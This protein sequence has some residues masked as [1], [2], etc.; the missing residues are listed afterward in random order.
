VN[1]RLTEAQI[2]WIRA[3]T[4]SDSQLAR[5]FSVNRRTVERARR[6]ITHGLLPGAHATGDKKSLFEA[7]L[8]GEGHMTQVMFT[9]R[10]RRDPREPKWRPPAK[11]L[12]VA[13]I[14]SRGY[15][16][17]AQVR[18]LVSILPEHVVVVSGGA[19]GVDQA[20]EQAA[21]ERGLAVSSMPVRPIDW[22][23]YGKRAGYER[24]VKL[25]AAADRV[26]AFWDG[27][28]PGTR[29]TIDLARKAGKPVKVY[30][31]DN[32]YRPAVVST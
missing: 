5:R 30:T 18:A 4:E 26:V 10:R 13:I 15:D 3:S 17:L 31:P 20:A 6:G 24:N 14:G 12:R 7:G 27:T 1:Q 2:R 21:Q 16:D 22:A 25:V 19:L 9:R 28:S 32:P 29:M 23:K 11:K 8:V